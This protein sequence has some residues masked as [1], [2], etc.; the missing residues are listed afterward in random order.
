MPVEK[1]EINICIAY[2][3]LAADGFHWNDRHD[4]TVY[5]TKV[6]V[7]PRIE[8]SAFFGCS[9]ETERKEDRKISRNT[10]TF[11]FTLIMLLMRRRL[12]GFRLL[13]VSCF[14]DPITHFANALLFQS[15]SACPMAIVRS[16]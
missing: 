12:V 5:C 2:S 14:T 8:R 4:G 15:S 9:D 1:G 3:T 16:T 11:T 7:A 6:I 13:A 10:H